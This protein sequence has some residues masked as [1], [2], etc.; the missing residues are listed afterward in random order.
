MTFSNETLSSW[1]PDSLTTI[2]CSLA[3]GGYKIANLAINKK[4]S[5]MVGY[6]Q[7]EAHNYAI[8]YTLTVDDKFISID[9]CKIM[10]NY[11]IS[12][13]CSCSSNRY[14]SIHESKSMERST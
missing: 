6:I 13:G 11:L 4:E 9:E 14:F 2:S 7:S 5:K 1:F 8:N 10:G 12:K 3:T